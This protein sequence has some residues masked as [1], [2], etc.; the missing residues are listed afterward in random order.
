MNIKTMI[1][2][3]TVFEIP[4]INEDKAIFVFFIV[5]LNQILYLP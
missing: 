2:F 1:Y 4:L 5:C 3:D